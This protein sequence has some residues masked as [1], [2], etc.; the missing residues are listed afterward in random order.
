MRMAQRSAGQTEVAHALELIDSLAAEFTAAA[1]PLE[2]RMA[3]PPELDEV[4]RLRFRTIVDQGWARAEDFPDGR[5]RDDFDADAIHIVGIDGPVLAATSRLVLP[6]ENRPLPT[7]EVFELTAA[8]GGADLGRMVVAPDYR[9]TNHRIFAG[10]LGRT[11]LEA[12]SRGVDG[13]VGSVS[14]A[15]IERYGKLGLQLAVLGP[16]RRYWGEERFPVC[17]DVR[18]T[19]AAL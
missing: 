11:W 19:A 8:P 10:L 4:F 7:E 6:R 18:A 9:E 17:L 3:T 14:A 12:R 13:L 2:F 1:R 16:A 5:E 15:V